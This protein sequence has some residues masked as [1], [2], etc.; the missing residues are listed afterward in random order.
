MAGKP[1]SDLS[2][3]LVEEFGVDPAKSVMIG[4]RL[5]TDIAFGNS[6]GMSTLLV[7]TGVSTREEVSEGLTLRSI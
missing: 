4:D 5:D 2:A 1:S 3:L 6:C 7:L